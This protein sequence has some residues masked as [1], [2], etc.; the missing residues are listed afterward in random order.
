MTGW[1]NNRGNSLC[2]QPFN[3]GLLHEKRLD[4]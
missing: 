2:V 4:E 1:R 3:P